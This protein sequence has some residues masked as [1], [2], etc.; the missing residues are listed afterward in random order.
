M[1]KKDFSSTAVATNSIC[2]NHKNVACNNNNN[3]NIKSSSNNNNI[4]GK[5]KVL[6]IMW[7]TAS[8]LVSESSLAST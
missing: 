7:S 4:Y 6:L 3:N 2:N 5:L 1:D 8:I